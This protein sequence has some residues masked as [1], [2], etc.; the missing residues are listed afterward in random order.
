MTTPARPTRP[1]TAATRSSV[2]DAL[3]GMRRDFCAGLD[4]RICRIETARLALGSDTQAALES[5]KF[6]AHRICGV[7]GSL[8]LDDVSALARVLEEHVTQIETRPLSPDVRTALNE[9]VNQFLD[10]LEHHLT[11]I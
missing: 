9:K 4:A 5:L 1:D 11:E 8:G 2:A 7:A 10:L 3:A 6:E